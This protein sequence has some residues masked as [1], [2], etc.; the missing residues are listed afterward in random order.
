MPIQ[1]RQET[2]VRLLH[3]PEDPAHGSGETW[4]DIA[5]LYRM[6]HRSAC[7]LLTAVEELLL[8][9][10]EALAHRAARE[11]M[12]G[13]VALARRTLRFERHVHELYRL[14]ET[15][16]QA[17]MA[18]T[19]LDLGAPDWLYAGEDGAAWRREISALLDYAGWACTVHDAGGDPGM[20][21]GR[22]ERLDG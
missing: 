10:G 2:M 8:E 3:D 1:D 12:N 5:A 11:S 21:P 15:P 20:A 22:P 17:Q 4:Q 7:S 14:A 16:A 13:Q 19:A 6:N 18:A 9:L